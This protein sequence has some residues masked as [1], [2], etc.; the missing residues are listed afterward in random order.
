MF[1]SA[2]GL[3]LCVRYAI[4][5]CGV[6]AVAPGGS[7]SRHGAAGRGLRPR[8]RRAREQGSIGCVAAAA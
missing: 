4:H 6:G 7:A 1:A 8:R 3:R 5:I 2:S